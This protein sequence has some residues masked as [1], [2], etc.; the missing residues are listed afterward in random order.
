MERG[1]PIAHRLISHTK[2][3]RLLVDGQSHER[4]LAVHYPN[5]HFRPS[6]FP[7]F[8]GRMTMIYRLWQWPYRYIA[9]ATREPHGWLEGDQLLRMHDYPWP[10]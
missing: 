10:C 2:V 1:T 9:P 3:C 4:R 6:Y 5:Y 7:R 8:P